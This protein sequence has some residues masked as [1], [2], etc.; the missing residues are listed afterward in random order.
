MSKTVTLAVQKWGDDLVVRIPAKL[1]KEQN[2]SA[3]QLVDVHLRLSA[4]SGQSHAPPPLE[5]LLA[6]FDREKHGGEAMATTP[7]GVEAM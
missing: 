2:L 1:A 6:Q 4:D 7:V 5:Q 3:G